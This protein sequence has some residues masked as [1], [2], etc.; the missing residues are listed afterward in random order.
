M[1]LLIPACKTAKHRVIKTL[2]L[3]LETT[4]PLLRQNPHLKI[5]HLVRDPR[6]IIHSQIRT[7]WFPMSEAN[8]LVVKKNVESLCSRILNDIHSGLRLMNK[9]PDKVKII[10][11]E[12]FSDTFRIAQYLYAFT[13][14]DFSKK[15]RTFANTSVELTPES[16]SDGNHP[17]KYRDKLAWKTIQTIDSEC[18]DVYNMLGYVVFNSEQDLRNHSISAIKDRLAF[19]ILNR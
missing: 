13:G 10:Q 17:F 5:I 18:K 11:Y 9:Y 1:P 2:R 8:Q 14:M 19:S 7:G 16:K 15:Y 3:S 4:E 6:G 12:D